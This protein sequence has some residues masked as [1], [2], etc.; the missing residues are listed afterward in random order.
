VGSKVVLFVFSPHTYIKG[1]WISD[2][3]MLVGEKVTIVTVSAN[4][5]PA[6]K[7]ELKLIARYGSRAICLDLVTLIPR[8]SISP[9]LLPSLLPS[10]LP[11]FIPSPPREKKEKE[12]DRKGEES[13]FPPTCV[14]SVF[15]IYFFLKKTGGWQ[16]TYSKRQYL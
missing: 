13:S 10:F 1:Y 16:E 6:L 8:P 12:R 14:F 5:W 2:K 15:L 3:N 11:P 4:V 7:Q 9:S